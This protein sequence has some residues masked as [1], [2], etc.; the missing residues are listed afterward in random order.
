MHKITI[1]AQNLSSNS[2]NRCLSIARALEQE[3]SVEIV[4]TTFLREIWP[5]ARNATTPIKAVSV[6]QFP[7]YFQTMRELMRLA[8][9]E[10]IIAC[11][12]R[13]PSFGVALLKRW[14]CGTPVILDID[15]DE[16]AMTLPGRKDSLLLRLRNPNG[17][18]TTRL[19]RPFFRYADAVFSVSRYFQRQYGG[20]IVPHGQ[21]PV[22]MN[23]ALYDA[24]AIRRELNIGNHENVVGFIGTPH[25][26]KGIDLLLDAVVALRRH[27]VRVL[28]VGASP[29]HP[30]VQALKAKY[31][32][33]MLLIPPQPITRAPYYLAA[34]DLVVLPQ[35]NSV[36]SLGQ[37]PA[38]L[39]DAMAMAKPIISSALSDIPYYLEGCGIVVPPD[40]VEALTENIRW[41]IEHRQEA[42][43]MG[44]RARARFLSKLTYEAMAAEI[45]PILKNL[46]VP[47]KNV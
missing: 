40:D 34:T 36:E 18:I 10:V 46:L 35:R 47:K 17:D 1:L 27:D 22:A 42:I 29:D 44:Q 39:S 16:V 33:F 9:G 45:T 38:K 43:K 5:P 23:P 6:E 8:D 30:V 24:H 20:V 25:P 32:K 4:G 7:R 37:M 13:L 12:L 19:I 26:H 11:K 3:Y 2:L 28:I 41:V 14:V 31:E 21:D 15:D